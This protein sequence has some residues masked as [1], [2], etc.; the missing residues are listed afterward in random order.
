MTTP[1]DKDGKRRWRPPADAKEAKDKR[2]LTE[3]QRVKNSKLGKSSRAWVERQLTD[4]YVRQAIEAG[5]RS[6]AAFKLK[7][8]DSRFSL[9]GRGGRILDL[10]CAPGGWLQVAAEHKPAALAGID[11]LPVAAVDGAVIVEGDV[12]DAAALDRTLRALGGPPTV[13]LSDM[14][15]DTTG[16]QQT[17][18]IRTIALAE[19]AARIAVAELAPGGAFLCKVFQ[20]GAQGALLEMLKQEFD[21]LRHWKPPAS[22]SES[23]ETYLI[24]KGR[25][26]ISR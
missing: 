1:E 26:P 2:T 15:A 16:H 8:I 20:G 17:D 5:Y 21:D 23:P 11:L 7:E 6:R 19:T 24:A 22:R 12:T 14:A 9:L 18:H 10:G 25:R 3:R 13:V 4:P